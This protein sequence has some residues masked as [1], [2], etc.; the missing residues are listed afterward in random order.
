MEIA[1]DCFPPSNPP[2]GAGLLPRALLFEA[3]EFFD[4]SDP[5]V[6]FSRKVRHGEVS[7][8]RWAIAHVL[9][10]NLGWGRRRVAQFLQKDPKAILHGYRRSREL[11]RSDPVFYE[12]V[13][14]LKNV[15]DFDD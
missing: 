15:I 7:P 13:T 12:A 10:E 3:C 5:E 14:R 9:I 1:A 8:A 2:L 6:I 11:Y 4:I